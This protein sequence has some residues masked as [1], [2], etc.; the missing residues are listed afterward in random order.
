MWRPALKLD[1][2]HGG[3]DVAG[4]TVAALASAAVIWKQKGTHLLFNCF[5]SKSI[6]TED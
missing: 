2:G 1:A 6:K 5:S 4:G 3:S